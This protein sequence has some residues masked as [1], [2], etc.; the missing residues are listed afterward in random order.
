MATETIYMCDFC[1]DKIALD[2]KARELVEFVIEQT[3]DGARP[4]LFRISKEHPS[5]CTRHACKQC[6]TGMGI[7]HEK[8]RESKVFTSNM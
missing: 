7:F 1:R 6:I 8:L 2:D 3:T 5:R 4:T